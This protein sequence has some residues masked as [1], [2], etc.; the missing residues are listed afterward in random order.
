[1]LLVD[2]VDV[3][4]SKDFYGN[5]Y[6]PLARLKDPTIARLAE[7]IWTNRKN[8]LSFKRIEQSSEFRACCERYKGWEFLVQEAVR[9]MLSDI[10]EVKHDYIVQFDKI[11]YKEQD[12]ISF[13]V[14]YGYKTMFAYFY[15]YEQGNLSKSSLEENISI[16]V[17]CGSFSYAEMPKRFNYIMGVTGT[18]KTLST[19]E[20]QIV[21]SAY[22]IRTNTYMP[23]VFGD[24]KRKFAKEADVF[25]ENQDDYFIRL[26]EKIDHA[27]GTNEATRRAVMVFFDSKERLNE[28]KNSPQFAPL[29]SHSQIMTEEVSSSPS[30]KEMLIKRSTSAGQVTLLTSVFGRG[31]DFV[32]RDHS[33]IANGGVHV[34]QAFLSKEFSEEVQIMGRTAR[35]GKD[36]SYSMILLDSDLEYFLGTSY[37]EKIQ[38]MRKNNTTYATL[39]AARNQIFDQEKKSVNENLALANKEHK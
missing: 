35:Q 36:G 1:M 16:G 3:F 27:L 26:R 37:R 2:E 23:S 10:V 34:I 39:H 31:T 7:H 8:N 6:T 25:I 21:E 5:I 30:E 24:N 14:V 11:G 12:G 22:Q 19:F 4:F 33:V 32:C 13:D 28:F 17:R 15:E 18:L 20:K 38:D 29:K 9:D